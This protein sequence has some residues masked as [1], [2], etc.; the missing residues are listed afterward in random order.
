M[1]RPAALGDPRFWLLIVALAAAL[2]ALARPRADRSELRLD[3]LFVLDI[4]G[5]M[6]VRD[7]TEGGKPQSRLDFVKRRLPEW[8]AAMPCGSRAGLAVFSERR[9]FLLVAP[10]ETCENFAPLAATISELDW[11]MAWEGDSH[12]ASGLIAS[13]DLAASFGADPVFLSDGQE[14]PPLPYSGGPAF[15]GT[16]G[17]ARGL[18]VGVGGY[19][20]SPIPKLD[21]HGLP[22][23][24]LG[25][26]DVLQESHLG[27]PPP[28]AENRPG[29]NPRNAPYGSEPVHGNEHLSSVRE[30][31]LQSLAQKTGL[32]YEH[33]TERSD[34]LAALARKATPV[35]AKTTIDL[36]PSLAAVAL[37]ALT[38]VYLFG[39]ISAWRRS[40]QS[41]IAA[42]LPQVVHQEQHM[43]NNLIIRVAMLASICLA[44]IVA[45]AHGPTPRRVTET[46][47]IA[48][49]PAKVWKA[50]GDFASFAA[51]NP[52]VLKVTTDKGNAVDSVRHVTLKSGAELVDSMDFYDAA[53]MTYTYRLMNQDVQKFPVSFYSATI[54]VKPAGAGSQVEWVGNFY[55]A[56]TQNEPPPG[57]DDDSAEKAMHDFLR[58]GLDGLKEA[59]QR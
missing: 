31:Y 11:R 58:G 49:S 44:S 24:F 48:A 27:P 35:F 42:S 2:V 46:V 3:T 13:I 9:P 36:R 37:L 38:S 22:S 29:F 7:Y 25:E 45:S 41:S 15:E 5:S 33:L 16:V 1:R 52:L 8:I 51:W 53:N 17:V 26:D 40:R 54:T 20:L 12:I 18:I 14:A 21:S 39:P 57:Q 50:V 34:L 23:G 47:D 32:G 56:D 4:T 55:R 59:V 6:T 30:P 10:V 28:G 43:K 19:A